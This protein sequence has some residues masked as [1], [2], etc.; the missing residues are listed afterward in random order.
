MA[1][2]KNNKLWVGTFDEGLYIIDGDNISHYTS[3]NSELKYNFISSVAF[4]QSGVAW[5]LQEEVPG[6]NCPP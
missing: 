6:M 3:S 2:D 1:L 4:D 5:I